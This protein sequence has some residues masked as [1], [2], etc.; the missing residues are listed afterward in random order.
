MTS[1]RAKK[2]TLKDVAKT[3]GVSIATVDRVMNNRAKVRPETKRLI[4]D[5]Y[6]KLLSTSAME[7]KGQPSTSVRALR[8]DFVLESSKPFVDSIIASV[9]HNAPLFKDFDISLHTH[10]VPVPFVLEEF[11][12]RLDMASKGSDGIVL[13]CREDP[14]ITACVNAL[15][16][17]GVPVVCL[18]TDIADAVRLGYVGINHVS[19]GKTAGS[20]L[21]QFIG[22]QSGELILLLTGSFRCQ[23]ERELGFRSII[24]EA[25]PNLSVREVYA[26]QE[27][28]DDCFANLTHAFKTTANKPLGIYN[29]GGGTRGVANAITSMGWDHKVLFVGH[30][31]ND[32]SL[33]LMT[34]NRMTAVIGQDTKSEVAIA[35]N[36][37]LHHHKITSTPPSFTPTAPLVFLKE[38]IGPLISD[39]FPMFYGKP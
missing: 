28:N 7:L 27:T 18:T 25:Y 17:R 37:L 16:K 5:T 30:E 20:L 4:L 10:E 38:N 1:T 26:S 31:L 24:R 8:F 29:T 13:V 15:S 9:R 34:T 35:I 23:Y 3:A 19:A 22:S 6:Q 36:A 39:S 2:A 12:R 21:G 14:A 11:T 32:T 33:E